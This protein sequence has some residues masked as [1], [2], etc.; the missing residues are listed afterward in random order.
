[1]KVKISRVSG[2]RPLPRDYYGFFTKDQW[3]DLKK[4][5]EA[6]VEIS[7]NNLKKLKEQYNEFSISETK[8]KK[9]NLTE[10]FEGGEE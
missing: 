3:N 7:E 1:M 6:E 5:K 9:K 4:G 2:I 8:Q 10:N